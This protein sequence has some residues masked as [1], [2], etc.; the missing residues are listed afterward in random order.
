MP[1]VKRSISSRAKFWLGA[2]L[3]EVS[4]SSQ[5][6][7]DGSLATAWASVSKLPGPSV[8]KIWFWAYIMYAHPTLAI[9]VGNWQ[10]RSSV[11]FSRRG[12][13]VTTIRPSHQLTR[14][15]YSSQLL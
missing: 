13:S 14:L 6:N 4:V 12:V 15:E 1:I 11:N 5:I 3:W 9:D 8:R 2:S 7:M 10:C